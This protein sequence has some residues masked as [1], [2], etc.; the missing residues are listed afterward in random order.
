MTTDSVSEVSFSFDQ[1]SGRA[2][3]GQAVRGEWT[4]F[5][6]VRST[7]WSLVVLIVTTI[8]L[9]VLSTHALR[10]QP[11]V[12]I[13]PIRR[14]FVGF[15]LGQFA[16]GV[17]GVLFISAEYGTG[18]IRSTLSV[19]PRRRV[20]V[21]AKSIVMGIVGL[22]VGEILSFATFFIGDTVLAGSASHVAFSSPGV[23]RV[24][25]ES[26]IYIALLGLIGLGI[27]TL[28]HNS[29]GSIATFAGAVLVLTLIVSAMP[30]FIINAVSRYLPANIGSS[31]FALRTPGRLSNVP[32]FSPLMGLAVLALYAV[33]LLSAGCVAMNR[34]D[35]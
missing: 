33:V 4:K 27:A 26:G 13:D 16:I 23:L 11:G 35:T 7:S 22:V 19:M 6:S 25:I 31:V 29:A 9:G 5:W 14:I 15:N 30:Q 12:V 21:I 18:Q 24:L 3:L 8:G 17:L 32:I 34:R 28:L 1:P 20:V 2:G 10:S